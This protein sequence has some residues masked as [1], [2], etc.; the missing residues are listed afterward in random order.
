MC[1]KI[2]SHCPVRSDADVCVLSNAVPC[3]MPNC[4]CEHRIQ[5]WVFGERYGVIASNDIPGVYSSLDKE[6]GRA[7]L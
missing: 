2:K 7:Y 1:S 5:V 4:F 6:D 3:Y